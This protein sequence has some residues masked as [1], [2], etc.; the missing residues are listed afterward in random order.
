MR[1]VGPLERGG[2]RLRIQAP[3]GIGAAAAILIGLRYWIEKD[4]QPIL[5]TLFLH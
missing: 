4:L 2:N 5:Q 3:A 1:H